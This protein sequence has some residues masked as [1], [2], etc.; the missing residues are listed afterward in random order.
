[1]AEGISRQRI[2]IGVD[3]FHT[4]HMLMVQDS[5]HRMEIIFLLLIR[6]HQRHLTNGNLPQANMQKGILCR[7]M[8]SAGV[9][10]DS[11][12]YSFKNSNSS[13]SSILTL[14]CVVLAGKGIF[15]LASVS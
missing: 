13:C 15:R 14:F 9:N 5:R 10:S 8:A 11:T 12:S 3:P 1:M 6:I 2:G 7:G 4:C